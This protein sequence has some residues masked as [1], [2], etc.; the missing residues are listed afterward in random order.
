M[1][2]PATQD[3][4]HILNWCGQYIDCNTHRDYYYARPT[5]QK[6]F[7]YL[8]KGPAKKQIIDRSSGPL[9]IEAI[10][11]QKSDYVW[12]KNVFKD[13]DRHL[14]AE[15]VRTKNI[16]KADL[17]LWGTT[18]FNL[19][20][21]ESTLFGFATPLNV[22]SKGYIDVVINVDAGISTGD[23]AEYD[24]ENTHTA[25]HEIGHA[26]GLSH[27]GIPGTDAPNWDLYDSEDTIMS[28]NHPEGGDHADYYS[29]GDILALQA[30]W[31]K[32]GEYV[33]PSSPTINQYV[34]SKEGKGK[35]K[36]LKYR[37]STFIFDNLDTFG[38]KGADKI[39]NFNAIKGDKL[40]FT[41]NALPGLQNRTDYSFGVATSKK[42]LKK[43]SKEC[44][45]IV[46][47]QPKGQLFYDSNCQAKGWGSSS[48]GGLFAILKN[49]PELT[50]NDLTFLI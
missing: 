16:K 49:K 25:L 6:I 14:E 50:T 3:L 41:A 45:D 29:E 8:Y 19:M 18:G 24:P 27:P 38:K 5:K 34:S 17:R 32:E 44:A 39:T 2:L 1:T 48:E 42:E 36:G 26:L 12:A 22:Q 47:Y 35:L 20:S 37:I 31:G 28:Y 11:V 9:E 10:G 40:L 33:P 15:F 7:Y 21:E 4:S 13:L 30:I 46:Y 23:T 43:M